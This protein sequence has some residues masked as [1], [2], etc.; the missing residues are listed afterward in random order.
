MSVNPT[1]DEIHRVAEWHR[2]Y[3]DDA[4]EWSEYGKLAAFVHVPLLFAALE[5]ARAGRDD[6][7]R[8]LDG[9]R[10]ELEKAHAGIDL[11]AAIVDDLAGELEKT[12]A[13]LA[14]VKR[15]ARLALEDAEDG[16]VARFSGSCRALEALVRED[17]ATDE[18]LAPATR[19]DVSRLNC[20]DAFI[21]QVVAD[22]VHGGSGS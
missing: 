17:Q 22:C 8:K 10:R 12:R 14:N 5:G 15:V 18:E 19:E 2:G 11:Q 13:E 3:T 6:A 9:V 21:G 7:R 1:S 20:F 16:P 4:P